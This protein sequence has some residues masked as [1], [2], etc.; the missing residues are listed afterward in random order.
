[1]ELIHHIINFVC[2][3]SQNYMY[4]QYI[5]IALIN[6]YL[7]LSFCTKARF[8]LLLMLLGS[9]NQIKQSQSQPLNLSH[10]LLTSSK[11]ESLK[12]SHFRLRPEI[13]A[14]TG[15]CSVLYISLILV[16]IVYTLECKRHSGNGLHQLQLLGYWGGDTRLLRCQKPLFISPV[17]WDEGFITF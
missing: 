14:A 12:F 5:A 17:S 16:A 4:A 7:K 8:S 6:L 10:N 9:H 11:G 1:M 3:Y 2:C 13:E 15:T